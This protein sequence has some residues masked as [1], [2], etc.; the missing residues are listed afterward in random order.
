[1]GVWRPEQHALRLAQQTQL[2]MLLF[3][4]R[5]LALTLK[6]GSLFSAVCTNGAGGVVVL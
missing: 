3:V 2:L 6:F 5:E 1:M 4:Y